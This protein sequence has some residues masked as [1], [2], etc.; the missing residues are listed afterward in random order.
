MEDKS[1]SL[2]RVKRH[3]REKV[4]RFSIRKYSFGAASVAVAALMFMGA[5]VVS[6][7]SPSQNTSSSTTGLASPKDGEQLSEA[8]QARDENQAEVASEPSA[9][10][11]AQ[12]AKDKATKVDSSRL[13]KLVEEVD[14]RL[15]TNSK[16]DPSVVSPIKERLQKGKELLDRTDAGQGDLDSLAEKLEKD[17]AVLSSSSKEESQPQGSE[18]ADKSSSSERSDRKEEGSDRAASASVP[19]DKPRRRSRRDLSTRSAA[20]NADVEGALL[21]PKGYISEEKSVGGT[22]VDNKSRT[23]EKTFMR[24][25]YSVENGQKFLTYDV[26]FQNNGH[27]L[28]GQT[29]QAFWFYPPRD[30][31]YS[32]SQYPK[33]P[34]YEAYYERYKKNTAGETLL[35]HNPSAFVK[36]GQT[37]HVPLNNGHYEDDG[38]KQ[39]WGTSY[40]HYQLTA[41]PTR[42]NQRQEMLKNLEHNPELNSIIKQGNNYPTLSYSHLLSISHNEEYAYKYHVKLR[43]RDNVTEEQAKN[44]GSMAVTTSSGIAYNAKAAYV[45]A[46]AGTR[47]V[48][49]TDAEAYPIQGSLHTKTVGD[50]LPNSDNPVGDKYVTSK[51][52][53]EFPS[54]MSWSWK[55]NRKPSTAQAGV[56]TYKVI[57]K[58]GD[59]SSSENANSGSDG[60]V[61]LNV[62]PKKPI[63]SG[64]E[65]KKGL[66]GQQLTVNVGDGVPDGSI[67]KLYD[68]DK[69]IGEGRTKGKTAVVTVTDA[70][71]GSPIT[72]ETIVKNG[73]EVKSD[74]SD[75]VTPT[76]QPDNQPPT[77][78]V[79][80]E[81]QTV[82]IGENIRITLDAQD[83][84]KV[85]LNVE[86]LLNKYPNHLAQT[87][88]PNREVDTDT[89]KKYIFDLGA[90]TTADLGEKTI[91]FKVTDDAGHTTSKQVTVKVVPATPATPT[92]ETPVEI[93]I[94]RKEN[95]DAVVT[96]KKPGGGL[97]P[98]GT[99]VE[100][101]GE[102]GKT[103]TVTIG[104]NGSGEVPNDKLPKGA[105]PGKGK[106]T[107]PN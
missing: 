1:N 73:G 94:T 35:S 17:L 19:E 27:A 82:K 88:N 74:R 31:L 36:N 76:P 3:Q 34:I 44:A 96:P 97:Y 38:G 58:Y 92:T 62:K 70:L 18:A 107:E 29:R 41:G 65:N 61:T 6:A 105:V 37:Y 55:D 15:S 42:D 103:I 78:T 89:H 93:G 5:N 47:L 25:R 71:P 43:L 20:D 46:A 75:A 72:A 28:P 21:R 63:I 26:Y 11:E 23:I 4:L 101:P 10:K 69:V 53:R 32:N 22:T 16:H 68:G 50:S 80:P 60:T 12:P 81:R 104:D 45:Y 57:A 24:S 85:K 39:A 79:T 13:R 51:S 49:S 9:N 14:A 91:T 52:G 59:G 40:S 48:S 7:D 99:T 66:T 87:S 90:A 67:V 86:D 56:F 95:G 33:G 30:L 2:S 84:T 77:L 102:N 64:F 8:G 98:K 83:D 100:I 106:V 54:G